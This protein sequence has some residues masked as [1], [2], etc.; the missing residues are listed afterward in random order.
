MRNSAGEVK[1]LCRQLSRP[2]SA[3]SGLTALDDDD[4][5]SCFSSGYIECFTSN[6]DDAI[7]WYRRA[8]ELNP[9]F[10]L[11]YAFFTSFTGASGVTILA[12][13]GLLMPI[14]ISAKYSEKSALG[15]LTGSSGE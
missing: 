11:A 7:A 15:L 1:P 14:L 12:L 4:P 6:Y 2:A 9:N 8:I 5:W 10:A 3:E 13:G